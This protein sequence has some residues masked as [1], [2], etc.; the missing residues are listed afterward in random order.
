M[1]F[2]LLSILYLLLVLPSWAQNVRLLQEN[3]QLSDGVKLSTT[4]YLP[5]QEGIYPTLLLR[6]PYNKMQ[7]R[8]Y[9][10]FFAAKGYA[11][12][13]QDVRGEFASEGEFIPFVNEKKDGLEVLDW[14]AKQGWCD[15]QIAGFGTSYIGFSALTLMDV[16][17]PNLKTVFNISGWIKP[18]TMNK[19]GGANHLMLGLPWLLHE[20]TQ[21]TQTK[22]KVPL[23]SL[24]K[25]LPL[26]NAMKTAG[27]NYP[28]WEN[29]AQWEVYNQDF[30]Y[31][32]VNIPVCHVV[33]WYDFVKEG[34]LENYLML[35]KNSKAPQKLVIGPWYHNQEHGKSTKIG[36]MDPGPGSFLGD[37]GIRELALRWFDHWLKKQNKG[38]MDEPEVKVF[39]LFANEWQT[40]DQ[41]PLKNTEP[42][43]F[44]LSSQ[45][46]ANSLEGDG[47]LSPTVPRKK[48]SDHFIYNPLLPVPTQGGANFHFFPDQLGIK[49]Q[50]EVE[51]RQDVLVYTSAPFT[52]PQS[53]IGQ[54]KLQ[55]FA[56]TAGEDTDFTAKLVLVDE[57][58][59]PFNVCDGI[60][61]ASHQ[62][63]LTH[64]QSLQAGKVY[65]YEIDLGHTAFRIQPGQ[66]IRLEVSSSNFPKYDRNLNVA[67][68]PFEA[69]NPKTVKQ[70]IFHE[71]RYPSQLILPIVDHK[72]LPKP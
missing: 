3:V 25:V 21:R 29:P 20:A 63:A 4:V 14:I 22:P 36:E 61:R 32:K 16:Q 39:E 5:P 18:A 9:G 40:A 67:T 72:T 1:K 47:I 24:F 51:K 34:V 28:I 65:K 46:S 23:D 37:Q 49:N 52:T 55:L 53:I 54:V 6:T 27:I 45:G 38:I 8:G 7:M 64:G 44:F 42:A 31:A 43:I 26:K 11:V 19:T 50:T 2:S 10:Q 66:R 41:F 71:K 48:T 57:K 68:A 12:V 33:G 58:G 70:S 59:Q 17:H 62:H 60:V 15:G 13:T 35:K 30:D 56:A 69:S